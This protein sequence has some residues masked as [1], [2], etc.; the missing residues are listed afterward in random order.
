MNRAALSAESTKRTP[1]FCR[2]W[3]ATIADR[4]PV[5]PRVADDEL[6][7]PAGVHL[8]E[9]VGVGERLDQVLDVEGGLLVAGDDLRDAALGG[10]L[11]RR[12]RR[13]LL[14]PAARHVG[15]VAL[16]EVD[17]VLVGLHQEVAAA[18]DAGVHLRP[19]HLLEG[20]LL[21][22]HHLGHPRRAEVHRGVALAHDHDVAEGRDVGAAGGGGPEEQADLRHP[23]REDDLVV[24]DPPGP[25]AAG[26]HLHLVGDPRAGGVDEVDH[27]HLELQRPL[28]DPEDLLDRLRPPGTRLHRRVVRHQ[29]RPGGRR[30]APG[31]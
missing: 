26:E 4:A 17:R 28:L 3:L 2:G 1:P 31:R 14:A 19:A 12:R 27:R 10:G 8:A 7:R 5:D 16:R 24:E 22:D 25:A 15:E 30:S 6:L 21:A 11:G 18:R 9:R 20:H 13:R 29:R 23:P